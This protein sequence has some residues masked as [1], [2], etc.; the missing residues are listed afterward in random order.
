MFWSVVG[1]ALFFSN[2]L[3]PK[4]QTE[5]GPTT[6]LLPAGTRMTRLP[7]VLLDYDSVFTAPWNHEASNVQVTSLLGNLNGEGAAV[8]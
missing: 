2:H 5:Q 6:I 4:P 8:K 7:D 3:F 1:Q